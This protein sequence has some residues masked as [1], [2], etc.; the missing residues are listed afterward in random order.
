MKVNE[1]KE[2]D[3]EGLDKK[4]LELREDLFRLKFQH[5]IRP[6]ENPSRIREIRRDIAR[7]HTIRNEQAGN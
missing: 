5:G 3:R 6:L 7:I 4:E 1:F 2:L